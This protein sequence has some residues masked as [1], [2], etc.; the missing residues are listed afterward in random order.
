MVHVHDPYVHTRAHMHVHTNKSF[1]PRQ[2]I[3]FHRLRC[4]CTCLN[5]RHWISLLELTL[6]FMCILHLLSLPHEHVVASIAEGSLLFLPSPS[7]STHHLSH[8][9]G[10]DSKSSLKFIVLNSQ[11]QDRDTMFV[12]LCIPKLAQRLTF[13]RDVQNWINVPSKTVLPRKEPIWRKG[14]RHALLVGI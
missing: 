1:T 12:P 13:S 10:G 14:N 11:H 5:L 9:N 2:L 6:Y 7:Y 3:C 4:S 8:Y